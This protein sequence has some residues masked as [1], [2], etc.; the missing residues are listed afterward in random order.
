[1]MQKE[2]YVAPQLQ[3]QDPLKDITASKGYRSAKSQ[4]GS[5]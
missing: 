5:S 4:S 1:M 3:K 2:M